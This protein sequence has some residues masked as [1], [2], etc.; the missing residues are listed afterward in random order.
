MPSTTLPYS[1]K[2]Q[3]FSAIVAELLTSPPVRDGKH[4]VKL[5]DD[6]HKFKFQSPGA[7]GV[8]EST[9]R[10]LVRELRKDDRF[11]TIRDG[12]VY[13][14][15]VKV[16]PPKK[17]KRAAKPAQD[18]LVVAVGSVIAELTDIQDLLRGI[19]DRRAAAAAKKP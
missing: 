2:E 16:S 5:T 12:N 3:L 18:R 9:I 13:T 14:W 10:A 1:K 11:K 4:F 15:W 17:R 19:A 6:P 8:P 7:K